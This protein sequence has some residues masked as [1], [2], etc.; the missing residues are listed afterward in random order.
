MEIGLSRKLKFTRLIAITMGTPLAS[1][2]FLSITLICLTAGSLTNLI[3]GIV[4]STVL[5]IMVSLSFGELVSIY[6]SAAGNRVFLKRPFGD[7]FALGFSIMWVLIILG[8]AGVESFMVGNVLYFIFGTIPPIFWAIIILTIILIINILG[9]EISG[10][11]QLIVTFFVALSLISVFIFSIFFVKTNYSQIPQSFNFISA[12][13]SSVIAVYFFLG[14]SRVTTLGE[15]AIDYK[16]G[17][18]RA[19]PIALSIVS[20]PF[21]L[22]SIAIYEHVP[23]EILKTTYIPQIVLGNFILKGTPISLFIAVISVIMS[24]SAFNAGILGTSRLIYALGREGTFPK[25]LGAIHLRFHT[26]YASLIF[27]YVIVLFIVVYI[28]ITGNYSLPILVAAGVESFM[29][30]LTSYSALWHYRKI[31]KTKIPFR[32]KGGNIIFSITSASYILLG[33]LLLLTSP[34]EVSLIIIF[35]TLVLVVF[36]YFFIRRKNSMHN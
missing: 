27:L 23:I 11:F 21:I 34:I 8:A 17:I 10:N 6:P 4:I 24:F 29:N 32:V 36:Y 15:E 20:I 19:M 13:S 25:F 28:F 16:K 1:S 5:V 18:P 22:G 30:A 12:L 9:V 26:P 7:S 3:V 31:E 35:G 33:I 2:V 14:F